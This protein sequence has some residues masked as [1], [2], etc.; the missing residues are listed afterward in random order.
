MDPSP[1]LDWQY[2]L[3]LV[4]CDY[5]RGTALAGDDAQD[6][7][8]ADPCNLPAP[9]IDSVERLVQLTQPKKKTK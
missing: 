9:L 6:V 3:V 7:M 1:Q 2:V 8:W 5:I 4:A